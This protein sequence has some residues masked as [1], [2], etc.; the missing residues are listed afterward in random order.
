MIETVSDPQEQNAMWNTAF[1][2]FQSRFDLA[3]S[4]RMKQG[5]LWEEQGDTAK[6]GTCYMDVIQRYADAGPFV[7]DALRRAEKLLKDSGQ[8]G[9]VV[10]LYQACWAKTVPPPANYAQILDESNW[11][12]IGKLYADKLGE[13]G[14]AAGEK[15]VLDKL[16]TPPR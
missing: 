4:I 8:E 3:A 6:A 1:A 5:A 16:K 2:M 9:K 14:N 12:R 10:L 11:Y 15:S 7:L 13:S